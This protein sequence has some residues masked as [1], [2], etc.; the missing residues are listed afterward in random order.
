MA[1]LSIAQQALLSLSNDYID[2]L[3]ERCDLIESLILKLGSKS[4][5]LDSYQGLFREIHSIK[6]SAGTHGFESISTVCPQFED[7]LTYIEKNQ[8]RLTNLKCHFS[9]ALRWVRRSKHLILLIVIFILFHLVALPVVKAVNLKTVWRK[10]LLMLWCVKTLI[11]LKIWR[12]MLMP[13]FSRGNQGA[14]F[15]YYF[16][17]MR[18]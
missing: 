3:P 9:M 16:S 17:L 1:K 5:N 7:W 4:L 12:L 6:G 18:R 8:S 10:T 11:Y 14:R 15:R 2:A 13:I